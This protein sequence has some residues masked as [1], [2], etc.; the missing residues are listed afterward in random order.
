MVGPYTAGLALGNGNGSRVAR[1]LQLFCDILLF[2]RGPQDVP[3]SP[4]LLALALLASLAASLLVGLQA[5]APVLALGRVA[6][7][8]ALSAALLIALLTVYGYGG[9][10]LQSFTALCATGAILA[11]L[12]WP[13]FGIIVERPAEDGLATVAMLLLWLL[14][15]WSLLVTAHILRHTLDLGW[16][17]GLLLALA[18]VLLAA[19]ATELVLPVTEN[20]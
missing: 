20:G 9:R 17:G 14:F 1:L 18:Y 10:F 13:L 2:R 16:A 3:A 19:G 15:A 4:A 8:T 6:L 5:F 12:A 7:E 11:L